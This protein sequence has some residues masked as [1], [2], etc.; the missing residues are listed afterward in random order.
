MRSRP[1]GSCSRSLTGLC[2]CATRIRPTAGGLWRVR[3][4][5]RRRSMCPEIL[6]LQSAY[7]LHASR[8]RGCGIF[9][10]RAVYGAVLGGRLPW[11]HHARQDPA[12]P[13]CAS[14]TRGLCA[15]AA[16]IC[17]RRSGSECSEGGC[18]SIRVVPRAAW[19]PRRS[20]SSYLRV[21]ELAGR[22]VPLPCPCR[23]G[24]LLRLLRSPLRQSLLSPRP[25]ALRGDTP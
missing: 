10:A 16:A 22:S 5:C 17:V 15:M 3:S 9:G 14:C 2:L 21:L 20:P 12:C 19:R 4:A 25:S 11:Y 23:A 8:W 7:H 18:R 13:R 24:R 6:R 1:A